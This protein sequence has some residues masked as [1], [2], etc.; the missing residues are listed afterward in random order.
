LSNQTSKQHFS[1]YEKIF[2]SKFSHLL[3]NYKIVGNKARQSCLF[4]AVLGIIKSRDVQLPAI[5]EAIK[6]GGDTMQTQ[7]IVHRLSYYCTKIGFPLLYLAFCCVKLQAKY[8]QKES[9]FLH[10]SMSLS[11]PCLNTDSC[12]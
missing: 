9:K 4:Q 10:Q 7:S 11:S 12:L 8:L 1:Q 5:A 2:T 3:S 6:M